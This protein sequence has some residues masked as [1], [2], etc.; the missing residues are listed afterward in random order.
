[1]ASIIDGLRSD[2]SRITKLLDA[3]ERQIDAFSEGGTL[4]FEIVDGVLHYC[5]TYPDLHHHP[6]EDMVFDR[7][8]QRD[9]E[10]V[11]TIGDLRSEHAKLA[12]L[13]GRF[14]ESLAA[15]EHDVPMERHEFT[16]IAKEFLKAYRRHILMEEKHF[17]PA[18]QASLT[19][20]DWRQ[21]SAQVSHVA[22]PLF[23]RLEDERFEALYD[24][25]VAWDQ[26]LPAGV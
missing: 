4:D 14:A 19:P 21:L 6:R 20:E 24:D 1:M 3:L 16:D 22:D 23:E 12:A 26:N 8:K 15:V 2:H 25:I 5:R 13:T 18:A 9:P 7:L 10:A 11:A 17:F